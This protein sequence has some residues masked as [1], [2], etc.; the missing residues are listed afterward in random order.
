MSTYS[1]KPMR[2]LTQFERLEAVT[3][4]VLLEAVAEAEDAL[5]LCSA[6]SRSSMMLLTARNGFH[7]APPQLPMLRVASSWDLTHL[8]ATGSELEAR[9]IDKDQLARVKN[10]TQEEYF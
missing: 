5:M 2:S 9:A 6:G 3:I 1:C 10:K 4:P 8:L 7:P